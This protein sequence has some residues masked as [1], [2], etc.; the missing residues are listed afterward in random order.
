MGLQSRIAQSTRQDGY[1]QQS[2]IAASEFQRQIEV[3]TPNP[4]YAALR[5][6]LA[7]ARQFTMDYSA[8]MSAYNEMTK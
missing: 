1:T 3:N 7:Q 2:I 5:A 8:M 4:D 6:V